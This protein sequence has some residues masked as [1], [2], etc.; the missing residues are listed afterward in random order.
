LVGSF[1]GYL[2]GAVAID[3]TNIQ[4]LLAKCVTDG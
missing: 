2:V 1:V 4:A 3:G